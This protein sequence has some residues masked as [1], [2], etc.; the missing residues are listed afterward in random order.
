MLTVVFSDLSLHSVPS[1]TR[2]GR[3]FR[4][5]LEEGLLL[6]SLL[7]LL[8]LLPGMVGMVS[9]PHSGAQLARLALTRPDPS[10]CSGLNRR[11]KL[12]S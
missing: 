3:G 2:R 7:Q 12:P 4:G 8:Q 11:L 9:P 1:K 6:L 10:A 5:N